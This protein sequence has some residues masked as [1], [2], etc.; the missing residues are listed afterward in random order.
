MKNKKINLSELE[1]KIIDYFKK[2]KRE[3]HIP[4]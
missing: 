2:N 3:K 1:I 4:Q